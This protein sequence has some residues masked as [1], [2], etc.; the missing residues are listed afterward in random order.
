MTINDVLVEGEP[1]GLLLDALTTLMENSE[2]VDGMINADI[3]WGG[4]SGAALVHTLGRITAELRANDM[5]SF[6]P[7]AIPNARTDEQRGAD[8]L[9]VLVRRLDEAMTGQ[10]SP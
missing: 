5:R 10:R 7:G 2:E 8:A 1:A 3:M 9:L 4:D 6:L